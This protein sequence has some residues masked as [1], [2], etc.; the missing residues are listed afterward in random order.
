MALTES[1][2]FKK[3]NFYAELA[4]L[5]NQSSGSTF[6][7]SNCTP[8]QAALK[9]ALCAEG[10]AFRSLKAGIRESNSENETVFCVPLQVHYPVNYLR[11]L[12]LSQASTEFVFLTDIDFLPSPRLYDYLKESAS[13]MEIHKNKLVRWDVQPKG[14]E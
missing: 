2:N 13:Q 10:S 7:S 8:N 5:T 6:G 14:S 3:E 11:N 12:A 1:A 4:S 9:E